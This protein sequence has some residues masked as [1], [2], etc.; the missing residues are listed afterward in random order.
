MLP[1]IIGVVLSTGFLFLVLHWW[2][3]GTLD[4]SDA[5]LLAVVFCGLIFGLFASRTVWQF[6]LAF[7][8]LAAAGSYVFYSFKQGSIRTYYKRRC[9]DFVRAI[10]SDPRNFAARE[11]LANTLYNL[12]ELNRA[13]DEMQAAVDMGAGYECQYALQKWAK[14]RHLRDTPNPVCRWCQTEN[15]ADARVCRRCGADLP[16]ETSFTRWLMGGKTSKSRYYLIIVSGV[17]IAVISV[18]LLPLK[19]AFIPLAFCILGLVGWAFI[20]SARS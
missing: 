13:I 11:Q 20:S 16:Y 2:S 10:Q 14:E 7:V 3:E 4:H 19:Y 6:A 12:G 9:E 18:L 1:L 17:G 8:P 15:D 5:A